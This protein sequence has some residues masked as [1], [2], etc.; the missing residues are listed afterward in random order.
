MSIEQANRIYEELVDENVDLKYENEKLTRQR[1][2]L[3]AACRQSHCGCT[4][5]AIE[6]GHDTDCWR[7]RMLELI[8]AIEKEQKT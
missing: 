6:A 2:E 7:P 5:E 3:V 4:V 1:D 8:A